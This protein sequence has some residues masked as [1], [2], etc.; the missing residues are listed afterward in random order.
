[1]SP[2]SYATIDLLCI[3]ILSAF[4]IR[5]KLAHK[6]DDA[7]HQFL[8]LLYVSLL[9]CVNDCIWGLISAGKLRWGSKGF[10]FFST[11]FHWLSGFTAW[12]WYRYTKLYSHSKKDIKPVKF[13]FWLIPLA[14]LTVLLFVNFFTPT[15]FHIATESGQLVYHTENGRLIPFILEIFYFVLGL[16]D[17]IF[18]SIREKDSIKQERYVTV[19]I[20]AILPIITGIMQ[21]FLPFAPAYAVGFMFSCLVIFLFNTTAENEIFSILMHEQQNLE[22][23]S[24]YEQQLKNAF[25]NEIYHEMLQQLGVGVIAVNMDNDI[26]FINDAAAKMYG[27]QNAATFTATA[28]ELIMKSESACAEGILGKLREMKKTGGHLSFEISTRFNGY[29]IKN[30]LIETH[31]V[32]VFGGN[33]LAIFC[34]ADITN[35]KMLEKELL[36]LS[37]TDPLTGLSN[38]RSGEQRTELLLLSN[39]AGMFC[40]LD[41]DHFKTINDTYGHSVGDKV[42]VAISQCLKKAF[43]GLDIIMRMGGDEF[44]V[45]AVNIDTKEKAKICL[46]RFVEEIKN[47]VVPELKG[48]SFS[49]SIGAVLCY[50]EAG[51][52]L[53]EYFKLADSV[54]YK[55]KEIRNNHYEFCDYEMPALPAAAFS[56]GTPEEV[57]EL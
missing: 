50:P 18:Y 20:F 2:V 29:K 27:Y 3:L 30:I 23:I 56:I 41:A 16:A 1:M 44:S 35:N 25:E 45:F 11:T 49:V 4:V 40:I 53:D 21:F 52:T 22:K 48:A 54:L 19:M 31:V 8:V 9:F 47:T 5:Q 43:R 26:V 13:I 6:K 36:H 39:K 10:F 12:A 34:L 37:E 24:S 51:K 42:L 14:I 38:R 32:D 7:S 28:D 57:E 33:R 17:T 15:V 55:S 46:D